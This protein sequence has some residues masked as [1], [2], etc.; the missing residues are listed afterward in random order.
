ML[1]FD[2]A[3]WKPKAS[4][5]KSQFGSGSNVVA[6]DKVR[7]AFSPDESKIALAVRTA[8]T[9][10]RAFC[11]LFDLTT[12][13]VIQKI[14]NFCPTSML[15][16]PNGRIL[17]T[18][19][20]RHRDY[21]TVVGGG[22]SANTGDDSGYIIRL[23]SA[24][25]LSQQKECV[26]SGDYPA[27]P[28]AF[29]LDS[30]ILIARGQGGGEDSASS[31]FLYAFDV[32]TG[33]MLWK[34]KLSH[35][36]ASTLHVHDANTLFAGGFSKNKI[37]G[38]TGRVYGLDLRSGK[39]KLIL[40]DTELW[41]YAVSPDG[42]SIVTSSGTQ[43]IKSWNVGVGA[44]PTPG[45][46]SPTVPITGVPSIPP[47][48][49]PSI[50]SQ[51]QND[52]LR[53]IDA[54]A[55]DKSWSVETDGLKGTNLANKSSFVTL[56]FESRDSYELQVSV[57]LQEGDG[58]ND[59][60]IVLPF[61]GKMR[62]FVIRHEAD[63]VVRLSFWPKDSAQLG[64]SPYGTTL[65][66]KQSFANGQSRTLTFRVKPKFIDVLLDGQSQFQLP[67]DATVIDR[68]EPPSS[69]RLGSWNNSVVFKSVA[70]DPRTT[71][72]SVEWQTLVGTYQTTHEGHKKLG[73]LLLEADQSGA[74]RLRR[75]NG[76]EA[77]KAWK[78]VEGAW[79]FDWG[80][81]DLFAI[82]PSDDGGVNLNVYWKE[83][84]NG[85]DSV[86]LPK[87]TPDV[88]ATFTKVVIPAI[89][90]R[91]ENVTSKG[92][93]M[94]FLATGEALNIDPTGIVDT[95]GTW[96]DE[97]NGKF[98]ARL[99]QNNGWEWKGTVQ[100]D[101]MVVEAFLNGKPHSKSTLSRR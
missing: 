31:S 85:F 45:G 68:D 58:R 13:A 6:S 5:D 42:N 44:S 97:G 65:P 56:P 8:S 34:E 28:A 90:G 54:T 27:H 18:Y 3:Q 23:L 19:Y 14:E 88:S 57:L 72:R 38:A 92:W 21:R 49:K 59:I 43:L 81:V 2:S 74:P 94:E 17:A 99:G 84:S 70:T 79:L 62:P 32:N 47:V 83:N 10:S 95:R 12:G 86:S 71:A 73:T 61:Q 48:N 36:L 77:T 53:S 89:I 87:R 101:T 11:V 82:V 20:G 100:R 25:D 33:K 91:W 24:D 40:E 52:L 78:Y 26:V 22:G 16:S 96:K 1:D 98:S 37:R 67:S 50:T 15:F 93:A 75:G 7:F 46:S 80:N 64:K 69:V 63:G 39:P 9:P 35:T 76:G 29:S 60:H 4:D 66:S 51:P 30:S 41:L 55:M